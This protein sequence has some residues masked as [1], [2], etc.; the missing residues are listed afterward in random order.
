MGKMLDPLFCILEIYPPKK[1]QILNS[2]RSM[3]FFYEFNNR[4]TIKKMP[5]FFVL[6]S[7]FLFSDN[8]VYLYML[9]IIIKLIKRRNNTRLSNHKSL[10]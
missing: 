7:R 3:F 10:I 4:L 1:I 5:T 2:K 6:H 8:Y 9:N